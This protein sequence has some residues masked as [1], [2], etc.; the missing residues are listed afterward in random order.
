MFITF[1]IR[2]NIIN[3]FIEI[4]V[5]RIISYSSVQEIINYLVAIEYI[6]LH[7]ARKEFIWLK[8]LLHI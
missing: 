2:Q 5:I 4:L 7:N 8:N 6:A 1:N 3:Y